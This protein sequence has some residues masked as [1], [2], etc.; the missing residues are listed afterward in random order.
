MRIRDAVERM[1]IYDQPALR[2]TVSVGVAHVSSS[3]ADLQAWLDSADTALYRSKREG[4]NQVSI[5]T[6]PATV[7]A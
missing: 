7:S 5:A 6:A 2:S 4:R 1:R 3:H